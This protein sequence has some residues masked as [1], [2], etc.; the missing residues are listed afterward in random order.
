VSRRRRRPAFRRPRRPSLS[1]LKTWWVWLSAAALLAIVVLCVCG[2]CLYAAYRRK[3]KFDHVRRVA[4][5]RKQSSKKLL[6]HH[7]QRDGASRTGRDATRGGKL[8]VDNAPAIDFVPVAPR[9]SRPLPPPP[10]PPAITLPPPPRL[11]RPTQ[12]SSIPYFEP[13]A[14]GPESDLE[15]QFMTVP[16]NGVALDGGNDTQAYAA[17]PN[18][19][20]TLRA[21][22]EPV[23]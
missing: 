20:E 12:A 11:A 18:N 6:V 22:G 19:D 10:A 7:P 17:L 4:M 8:E 14:H 13:V 23:W 15:L 16:R 2:L 3:R 21:R 5:A 9:D 1:P